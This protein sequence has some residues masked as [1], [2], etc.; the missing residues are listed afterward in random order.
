MYHRE[1][2]AMLPRAYRNAFSLPR[3]RTGIT[4][5]APAGDIDIPFEYYIASKDL[6]HET[7]YS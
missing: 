7:S 4:R 2:N 1:V 3:A 6:A 5:R